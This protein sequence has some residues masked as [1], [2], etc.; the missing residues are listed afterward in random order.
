MTDLAEIDIETRSIVSPDTVRRQVASALARGLPEVAQGKPKTG[1]L[2]IYAN[3]PSAASE[4]LQWPCMALNGAVGLFTGSGPTLWAASDSQAL[5][6][7]FVQ[8]P[9]YPTEHL[10]ASRCHPDVFEALAGDDVSI[11]HIQDCAA[12]LLVG[13]D[14]MPDAPSIT[15]QAAF[16][17]AYLGWRELVFHG[18]DGCYIAGKHHAVNQEHGHAVVSMTVGAQTFDTTLAWIAEAEDAVKMLG[19]LPGVK[20]TVVGPGMIAAFIAAKPPESVKVSEITG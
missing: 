16:L 5:V 13:R 3:G 11:W 7:R 15:L 4:P 2:H 17:A 19:V 12:D 18:W 10:V 9:T 14:Q 8:L 20:V 6:A 1:P